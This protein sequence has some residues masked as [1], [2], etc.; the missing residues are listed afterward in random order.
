MMG[1]LAFLAQYKL[2]IFIVT[3]AL[4][5]L[6]GTVG[7]VA[8]N[9]GYSRASDAAA[10]E[11]LQAVTRAIAEAERIAA[12]DA[13]ISKNNLVNTEKVKIVTRTIIKEKQ[14][15]AKLNPIDAKCALDA[16]RMRAIT[17]AISGKESADTGSTNSPVP[18]AA[19]A[20]K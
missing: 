7:T 11:K 4:V 5:A 17:D 2:I 19:G 1:M 18:S 9:K 13:E 12:S 10:A 3:I 6:L 15:Y 8:Y 16:Y 14:A 20:N